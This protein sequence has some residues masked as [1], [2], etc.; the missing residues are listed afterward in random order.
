M[1]EYNKDKIF[2]IMETTQC[3]Y[4]NMMKRLS[5]KKKFSE[6]VVVFYSISLIVYPLTGEFFPC[7]FDAKLS[8]Y[9][10]IILSIVTLAYSLVNGSAKYAERIEGAEKVLNSVKTLKR[11]LTEKNCSSLKGNYDKLMEK[12]EYRDD[13]DFFRTVKQKCSE[14]GIR[15][16]KYKKECKEMKDSMEYKKINN[17]LSEIFPFVQQCKIFFEF[18]WYSL[19]LVVPVVL[20]LICFLV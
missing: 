8:N 11:K 17:Y 5:R 16:Y 1:K 3:N 15:W 2:D 9:F 10:G 13:V 19:V 6:F 14:L 20:F 12:A 7:W 18:I 4:S